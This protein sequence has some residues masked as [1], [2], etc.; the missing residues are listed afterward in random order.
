MPHDPAD[1]PPEAENAVERGL[2]DL[3]CR[4]IPTMSETWRRRY[5]RS[6]RNLLDESLWELANIR[7]SRIPNP[8]EYIE[9]RR[10]VG[11][12]PWSANLVEHA[13][14][15]EVPAEIA[16]RRPM[17]VLVDTFADS[18]HLRNDLFS[19]Q[20]ETEQE[21]EINNAVLV[22]QNV[23]RDRPPGGGGD[24]QRAAHLT[25]PAV[26]AHRAHRGAAAPRGLDAGPQARADVARY[27]HGLQDWQ[28]GGHEWHLRSSRYMRARPAATAHP[29]WVAGDLSGLG[30]AAVRIAPSLVAT[31][32][33]RLR[34]HGFVPH[35]AVGPL[36]VPD[37]YM[38]FPARLSPHLG[39]AR[40]HVVR[41][42]R[43]VGLFEAV[44]AVPM[45][46]R[47][48]ERRLRGLDLALCAAGIHPDG[49][50]EEVEIAGCWLAWGTYADDYYPA[51]FGAAATWLA[52][53]RATSGCCCSCPSTRRWPRSRSPGSSAA[54]PRSGGAPWDR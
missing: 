39:A 40:E 47:W 26:R 44:P 29:T 51:V 8:I 28:A 4:T 43:R 31:A 24:R 49:S 42:A 15:A 27:V 34:K 3:W 14:A 41:W 19:Y 9:M 23:L 36:P 1:T 54:S 30:T 17:R 52:L 25:A 53:G 16:A 37:L 35:Q 50:L 38:P 5:A 22:A 13:V 10:K 45:P 33:A 6:T 32:P 7:E 20:R 18:I 48:D 46:F 12:A 2:A 21:G 11:G